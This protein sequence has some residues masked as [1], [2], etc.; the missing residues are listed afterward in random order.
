[1]NKKIIIAVV[2]VLAVVLIAWRWGSAG[3]QTSSSF[4][5]GAVFPM[6]G[7]FGSLGVEVERG[8][9]LAVDAAKQN[10]IVLNYI[11]Q[12]DA[13]DPTAAVNAA[14]QLIQTKNADALLTM[15]VQEA[16]PILPVAMTAQKPLLVTWDSNA[17]LKTAGADA[18]SIGFSTEGAG[19]TMANH[20]YNALHLRKVAVISQRDEWSDIISKAFIAQ[21]Q[22]LGGQI[23]SNDATND[24][25]KDFRS[26][27][28]KATGKNPDGIY[29]PLASPTAISPFLI[30][31]SQL[32]VK[33]ALMTG[34]GFTQDNINEAKAA[35]NNVYYTQIYADNTSALVQA[36]VAKYHEQPP[37]PEFA[38]FGYDGVNVLLEAHRIAQAQG[39]P[40]GDA[41]KMV[42]I[43]GTGTDINFNGTQFSARQEKLYQ[44]VNG[45]TQL[46]K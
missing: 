9:Q 46:V 5:I 37:Y 33:A 3:K 27:I 42:K 4:T 15:A 28:T 35:A 16:K 20:A 39:I 13:M 44:V 38:S 22:S 1:M 36:Y 41:I 17:F 6:T 43:A 23:V 32:G 8:A 25:Q 7:D 19:Q 24:D 34:D 14:N 26:F 11:S 12:D 45:Q 29:F 2:V 31:A 10:G 30:Q 18:F 21:F 40:L